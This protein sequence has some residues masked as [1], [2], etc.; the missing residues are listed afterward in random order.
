MKSPDPHQKRDV[1]RCDS[2]AP[3]NPGYTRRKLGRSAPQGTGNDKLA[4][5]LP[6]SLRVVIADLAT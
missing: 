2:P 1:S 6:E 5:P 4:R 3:T